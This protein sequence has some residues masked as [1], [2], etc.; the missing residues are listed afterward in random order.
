MEDYNYV[1]NI[2]AVVG[3]TLKKMDMVTSDVSYTIKTT[4]K[5]GGRMFPKKAGPRQLALVQSMN[6][7]QFGLRII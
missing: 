1:G 4:M 6:L 7:L 3:F 5:Y 2:Q